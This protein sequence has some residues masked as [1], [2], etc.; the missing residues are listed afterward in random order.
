MTKNELK[1]MVLDIIDSVPDDK[2]EE[3]DALNEIFCEDLGR[4]IDSDSQTT[5]HLEDMLTLQIPER[6]M[7]FICSY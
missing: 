7:V 5:Q 4:L 2:F 6:R 1:K 3:F